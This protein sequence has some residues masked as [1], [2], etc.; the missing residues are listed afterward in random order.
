MSDCPGCEAPLAATIISSVQLDV[1]IEFGDG[2]A[3][4]CGERERILKDLS[5]EE[6]DR[7][8]RYTQ[9]NRP[10]L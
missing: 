4:K 9:S 8:F 6:K 10:D 2:R 3:L 1:A 5:E 7:L